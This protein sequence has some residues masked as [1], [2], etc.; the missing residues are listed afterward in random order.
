MAGVGEKNLFPY[1]LIS[2][3]GGLKIKLTTHISA[4]ENNKFNYIH[5]GVHKE[6]WLKKEVTIGGLYSILIKD[7][8]EQRGISE[9]INDFLEGERAFL[10]KHLNEFL[11]R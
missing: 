4:R 6:M 2:V 10:E 3:F 8:E 1:P 5:M 7:G 9:R 11:E